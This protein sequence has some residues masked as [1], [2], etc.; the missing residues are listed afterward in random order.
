[1]RDP[2]VCK[3]R[4]REGGREERQWEWESKWSGA[5]KAN[6]NNGT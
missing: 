4:E 3:W 1:M 6:G 5:C 2:A